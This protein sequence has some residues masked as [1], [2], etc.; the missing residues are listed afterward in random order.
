[1]SGFASKF[2]P[3]KKDTAPNSGG[4][5]GEATSGG[6]G[7]AGKFSKSDSTKKSFAEATK[8]SRTSNIFLVTGGQ[9]KSGRD[10][11][12]YVLV[13]PTK[14]GSFQQKI[15]SGSINLIDYGEIVDS[16]FGKYPPEDVQKKMKDEYNFVP[17]EN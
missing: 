12:Y 13:E 1:M 8:S 15:K 14:I 2:A 7:F 17:E 11:W 3:K 4:G 6:G 5:S 9:D 16:D 10:A